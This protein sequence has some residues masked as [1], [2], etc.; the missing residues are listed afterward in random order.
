[1]CVIQHVIDHAGKE[2]R[3][4]EACVMIF[5]GTG[6]GETWLEYPRVTLPEPDDALAGTTRR[7]E[8]GLESAGGLGIEGVRP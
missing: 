3:L 8:C 1:M 7:M 6:F 4:N 5:P 2:D